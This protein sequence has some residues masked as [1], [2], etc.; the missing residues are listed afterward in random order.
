MA[1]KDLP[2]CKCADITSPEVIQQL[3]ISNIDVVVIAMA[4]NLE[5][6]VMAV[7]LCKEA[8]VKTVIAKCANEMHQKI[9]SRVGAD[10]VLFP[11]NESGIRLAKNL[12]SSGFV[13]MIALSN[14]FSI[15]ELDPKPEW[16]GKNLIELNLR[17]H[18]AI[19]VVAIRKQDSISVDINP[20]EILDPSVKLII[21]ANNK[22]INKLL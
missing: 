15:I 8:G 6:T 21:I 16:I 5:A 12:V 19:N 18:Y 20:E 22:S 13:D 10:E 7:T 11:E 1:A 3:G 9:L 14:N 2:I 4:N 17:K